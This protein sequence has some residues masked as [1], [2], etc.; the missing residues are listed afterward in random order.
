VAG[1]SH[2]DTVPAV[3]AQDEFSPAGWIAISASARVD[4]HSDFGTF[5]SPRASALLRLPE[6]VSVRASLGTGYAPVTPVLDDV[7]D[8]GFGA[9]N[10]LR[11]LR[12]ERA[13]SASLDLKWKAEPLEINLSAFASEI[14]HPLE[15]QPAAQPGRI[16][17]LNAG[18]PFRVTGAELLVGAT[19]DDLHLLVNTTYLDATEAAP[20]G[21]GRAAERLP[22]LSAEIATIFEF[23]GRG[24]AGVEIS[25][26]GVQQLYD[27]PYRTRAPA[28]LEINALAEVR[29][30]RIFVFLNGFNL[31]GRRQQDHSPLLRPAGNPGLGGNPVESAWASLVGRS[32]SLGF[33]TLL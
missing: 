33:R 23:E 13:S 5:F 21:G 14:R 12:A 24:R 3:F 19:I 6:N 29:V 17:I 11:D 7:E 20:A 9:V 16:E 28:L 30:G 1:I 10:P 27:D 18:R 4:H 22:K 26:T 8:V 31:T 2:A 15:A 25:Y 32:F